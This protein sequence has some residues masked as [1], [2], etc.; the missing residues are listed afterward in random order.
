M[1]IKWRW[2]FNSVLEVINSY[3][4][5]LFHEVIAVMN[6]WNCGNWYARNFFRKLPLKYNRNKTNPIMSCEKFC[7][8]FILFHSKSLNLIYYE[9]YSFMVNKIIIYQYSNF[10]WE[11]N[12][13]WIFLLQSKIL[14]N[15]YI[16]RWPMTG[17]R[18]L[19][20][21]GRLTFLPRNVGTK[22]A[23]D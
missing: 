4:N 14:Q 17:A 18:K 20:N 19:R 22:R 21:E 1:V 11:P 7:C 2:I 9:V 15:L 16:I 10:F 23:C 13:N 6:G 3:L 8:I 12:V 5:K